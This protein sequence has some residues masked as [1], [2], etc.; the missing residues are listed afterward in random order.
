MAEY[1]NRELFLAL[2][3]GES[4]SKPT[5]RKYTYARPP[6]LAKRARLTSDDA[7]GSDMLGGAL[8]GFGSTGAPD[9]EKRWRDYELDDRALQRMSVRQ[10]V[11]LLIDLS[12]EMSRGL[13]DFVRFCSPSYEWTAVDLRTGE[14][15][16]RARAVVEDAIARIELQHGSFV[17]LLSQLFVGTFLRGAIAAELVLD[18]NGRE[19]VDFIPLDPAVITFQRVND[20]ER[21]EVWVKGQDSGN[22]WI[23]LNVPT[24]AYVPI[25]PLP[26]QPYGRS[27]I[28]PAVFTSVFLLSMLHDL[29]RVIQQQGYPRL[30]IEIDVDRLMEL[31][32]SDVLSDPDQHR[33]FINE[34]VDQIASAYAAL[35]P[36]HTFVHTDAVKM[37]R[38]VGTTDSSSLGAIKPLVEMLERMLTRSL[39]TVPFL[40]GSTQSQS[41]TQANRQWE[42]F[43]ASIR[44]IQEL[45]ANV[46]GNLFT[47]ALEA[48]GISARVEFTFGELR[49]SEQMRDAQ[50]EQLRIQN[51]LEKL[52]A[53]FIS[54]ED[55][56]IEVTGHAPVLP[57]MPTLAPA[58]PTEEPDGPNNQPEDDAPPADAPAPN[59][60]ADDGD[61]RAI[62]ATDLDAARAAFVAALE[63]V[64]S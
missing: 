33:N 36:D 28:N 35:E 12:P 55:A 39:K 60:A 40:M 24:V 49:Q 48:Q 52:A 29:R 19:V 41:E 59:A 21:G 16:D 15:N 1:T 5:K 2:I 34:A 42:A 64:M 51:A 45:A 44:N 31:A 54:Y 57:E 58:A 17:V 43:T 9:Q 14:P 63:R 23:P 53:G 11:E 8:A 22:E 37:N 18:N 10:I 46:L 56:G 3:R 38:P 50:V 6:Q 25:D 26:G 61:D 30:D 13:W 32:P 62:D 27:V 7:D 20:P 47:A 4:L